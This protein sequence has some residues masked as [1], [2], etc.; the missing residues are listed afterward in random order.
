VLEIVVGSWDRGCGKH[1][2][3]RHKQVAEGWALTGT[4]KDLHKTGLPNRSKIVLIGRKGDWLPV[5]NILL[6]T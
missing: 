6:S 2:L 1:G 4:R 5:G 3:S